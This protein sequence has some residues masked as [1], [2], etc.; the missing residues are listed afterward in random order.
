MDISKIYLS[1]AFLLGM[2]HTLEPG[3]GKSVI[4]AYLVGTSG[5]TL[6]A[7]I[8]GLITAFTHTFSVIAL[9]VI[10][11]FVSEKAFVGP[12]QTSFRLIAGLMIL[13]V[14]IWVLYGGIKGRYHSHP[15][16]H[17]DHDHPHGYRY[18]QLILMGFS[19]GMVPCPAGIAVLLSA[20]SSGQINRGLILVLI[21]SLGVAF[22]I[23]TIAITAANVGRIAEMMIGR[24]FNRFFTKLP[25]ISG[26]I[27][28]LLGLYSLLRLVV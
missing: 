17:H 24:R 8:L 14:G 27:I 10:F 21:F 19:A 2:L 15:H 12:V 20:I 6:D 9:G 4:A 22:T 25:I 16:I 28:S 1:T 5:R 26:I 11:K 18:P 7:V 23:T 13:G 3:H